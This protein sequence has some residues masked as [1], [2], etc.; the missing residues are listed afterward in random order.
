MEEF[1]ILDVAE[2]FNCLNFFAVL[3]L[4]CVLLHCCCVGFVDGL[5]NSLNVAPFNFVC[6]AAMMSSIYDEHKDEDGF[7]YFTYSGENTFG[8]VINCQKY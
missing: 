4:V 1:A 3:I 7:L 6:A 8:D 5:L 2:R